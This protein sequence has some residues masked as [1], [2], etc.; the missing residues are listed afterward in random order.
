[1]LGAWEMRRI[2]EGEATRS[3]PLSGRW[4]PSARGDGLGRPGLPPH[5]TL[6]D[7]APARMLPR[8]QP[9]LPNASSWLV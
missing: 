3:A 2:S 8:G 7:H 1:M 6:G 5:A 9:L 4:L